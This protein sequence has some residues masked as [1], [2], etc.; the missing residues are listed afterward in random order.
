MLLR[1]Y[2]ALMGIGAAKIDLVLEKESYQPGELVKGYFLLHGGT[3]EQELKR[4]DCDLVAKN[5][6]SEMEKV[7]NSITILSSSKIDAGENGK[8]PV[9]FRLPEVLYEGENQSG[10]YTFKTKLTFTK[11]AESHDLDV[12]RIVQPYTDLNKEE[13]QVEETF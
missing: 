5:A 10:Y 13:N 7:L 9:S 11:G 12:I 4:I 8:I 1:K 3:V 6:S 2:M